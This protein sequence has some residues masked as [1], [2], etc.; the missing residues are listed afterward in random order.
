MDLHQ[1]SFSASGYVLKPCSHSISQVP[2]LIPFYSW[3]S[4]HTV[5][6]PEISFQRPRFWA[7]NEASPSGMVF[8]REFSYCFT[9]SPLYQIVP[10]T[11]CHLNHSTYLN[12]AVTL[13]DFHTNCFIVLSFGFSKKVILI[14]SCI[15][16]W[17]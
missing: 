17:V 13:D 9:C 14:K 12:F 15:T 8:Q 6:N 16:L 4:K 7:L 2:L 1:D 5:F 10:M 11:S 3:R